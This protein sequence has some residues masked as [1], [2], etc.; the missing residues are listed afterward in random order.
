M[1]SVYTVIYNIRYDDDVPYKL[2][3]IT[4]IVFFAVYGN[5][6][7]LDTLNKPQF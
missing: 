1:R 2:Y 3:G 6:D 4:L 7:E 5:A